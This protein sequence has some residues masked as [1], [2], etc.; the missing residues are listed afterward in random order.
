MYVQTF[1]LLITAERRGQ[2]QVYSSKLHLAHLITD[3]CHPE[4][5]P[6]VDT[7]FRCLLETNEELA[8]EK[9]KKSRTPKSVEKSYGYDVQVLD[10]KG[11]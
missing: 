1:I 2:L 4:A 8:T 6:F 10:T 11:R 9:T 7:N 5:C 3:C